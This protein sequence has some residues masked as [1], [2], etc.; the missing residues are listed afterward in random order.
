MAIPKGVSNDHLAVL[1]DL[2]AYMLTPKAQ[3]YAWDKGYF[4]PGPAVK[5]VPL[6]MAPASS[7]Q[8]IKE[9]GRPIYA[10]LLADTPM[11]APLSAE[12]MVY[13]FQ[14]W[15]QQIGAYVGK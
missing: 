3:A 13:A 1:L 7:Q 12:R 2:M 10:T 15:D 8:A 9:Y 14:R 5:N 4:Y 6:S 11:D